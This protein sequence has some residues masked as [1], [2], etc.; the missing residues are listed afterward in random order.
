[1]CFFFDGTRVIV[2]NAYQKKTAKMPSGEKQRALKAKADYIKRCKQ[3]S[4]YE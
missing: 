4:Y 1:L 2:V 3:G